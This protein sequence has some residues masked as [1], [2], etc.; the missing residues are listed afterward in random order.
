VFSGVPLAKPGHVIQYLGQYT[1]RV[2]ISNNRILSINGTK[3]TFIAKDYQEKAIR[4]PVTLD[5]IEFLR[6]FCQHILPKGFVKVR[7]SG[8]YNATT[9]RNLELEFGNETIQLNLKRKKLSGKPLND[10]LELIYQFARCVKP[11]L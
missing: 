8:I 9:K 4:K 7:R 3:V 2:A 6:R 5:G 1:H 10:P 11:V